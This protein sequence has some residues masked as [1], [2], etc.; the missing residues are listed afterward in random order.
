ML[1][2]LGKTYHMRSVTKICY[3]CEHRPGLHLCSL[4]WTSSLEFQH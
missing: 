1:Y 3:F 4:L 2:V